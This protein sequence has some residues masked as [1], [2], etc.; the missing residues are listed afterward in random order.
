MSADGSR[1]RRVLVGFLLFAA[2][3]AYF[4]SY[5]RIGLFDD[6]GYML[7][8]VTRILDG[9]VIY[10]DFHH[11]Y[12]PGRFYLFA[13]LFKLFGEDLLVVRAT[14]VALRAGVVLLAWLAA[15]RLIRGPLAWAPPLALLALPGPWHKSF[16]HLFLLATL[17]AGISLF[18]KGGAL[19]SYA[20][21]AIVAL[22]LL[23]RQD[24]GILAGGAIAICLA[25]RAI[26]VRASAPRR[27]GAADPASGGWRET[28]TL[29]AARSSFTART[30]SEVSSDRTRR[31]DSE[32]IGQQA[33][34][35][36]ALLVAGFASL[37]APV[38]AYF[39]S[40]RAL[41]PLIEKLFLAGARD[42]RANALP[43]P[44]LLPLVPS[45]A[46]DA[47]AVISLLFVKILYYLP[48][49]T[50][51]IYGAV[52]A[53]AAVRRRALPSAAH[54]LVLVL[55]GAALLQVAARSDLPHLY[56]AIGLVYFPWALALGALAARIPSRLARPA[57]IAAAL[58]FPIVLT[59]GI[60]LLSS[61][62]ARAGGAV[63]LAR[64]GVAV[65]FENASGARVALA[66]VPRVPLG[67][68]RARLLVSPHD[69]AL[70]GAL[71]RFLDAR[72]KP[73]DYVLTVPGFQLVYFL[74]DRRNPTPFPHV[75]RAFD[76]PAEE[77]DYIASIDRHG[78][79]YVFF[80]E[81]AIDGRPER[82]FA[83]YAEK[84]MNW[85]T[86]HYQPTERIGRILALER[87]PGVP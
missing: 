15:R 11:T 42:N 26:S 48:P 64:A 56:Q 34:V 71:G 47:G 54:V 32:S 22:A 14:W 25:M 84:T 39:A 83:L 55:G 73:G 1:A 78:A 62:A 2:S 43:F 87:I 68:P 45:G 41:G 58:G 3:A 70:L 65:P 9:Q 16:F 63:Y 82:R 76:S 40:Q 27:P 4:A 29:P 74:F 77:D 57:V 13:G 28:E 79:R 69:A 59:G 85:L 50:F 21:G 30:A 18:E 60:V 8:G 10:R 33:R 36:L 31:A 37:V 38:L 44:P 61:L 20:V 24:V 7:E 75:R 81:I 35:S 53:V 17:L 46:P 66:R 49:V 19:R 72:T 52:L 67:L 6:E 12:A 86:T 80:E 5:A 51:A 23:F